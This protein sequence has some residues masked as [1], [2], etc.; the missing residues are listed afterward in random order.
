MEAENKGSMECY[1][2]IV[3]VGLRFYCMHECIH[4]Q[5]CFCSDSRLRVLDNGKV[6]GGSLSCR[7]KMHKLVAAVFQ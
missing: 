6:K 7:L 5:S 4:F 1:S 3:P 2:Y